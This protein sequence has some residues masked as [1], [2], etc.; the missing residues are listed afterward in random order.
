MEFRQLLCKPCGILGKRSVVNLEGSLSDSDSSENIIAELPKRIGWTPT[1][2]RERFLHNI[3]DEID[4]VVEL[5]KAK[6]SLMDSL[7]EAA[8]R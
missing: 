2:N 7:F 4:A 8:N 3:D 1:W 5:G 6:S